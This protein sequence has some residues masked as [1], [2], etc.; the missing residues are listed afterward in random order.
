ML[1]PKT[2]PRKE[3]ASFLRK[4]FPLGDLGPKI[5]RS[6]CCGFLRDDCFHWDPLF[7]SNI[8]SCPGKSDDRECVWKKKGYVTREI[9]DINS[10]I[11]LVGHTYLCKTHGKSYS[12]FV[13]PFVGENLFFNETFLL[14]REKGWTIALCQMLANL[15]PYGTSFGRVFSILQAERD[16]KFRQYVAAST[17]KS[18]FGEGKKPQESHSLSHYYP[19]PVEKQILPFSSFP[20][21]KPTSRQFLIDCWLA[22]FKTFEKKIEERMQRL[23]A[24]SLSVD[25]TFKVAYNIA[26]KDNNKMVKQYGAMFIVLNQHGQV[27]TWALAKTAGLSEMEPVLRAFLQRPGQ[28]S[29]SSPVFISDRCC[30]DAK[31]LQSLGIVKILL[32]LFHAI[33]RICCCIAKKTSADKGPMLQEMKE[34]FRRPD[35][36]GDTRKKPT[37]DRL[38]MRDN[39]VKWFARWRKVCVL[40]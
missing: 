5:L 10:N 23:T 39:L 14:S 24:A 15:I 33:R 28:R 25:H 32:D 9:V 12:G 27:L 3:E 21:L 34:I 38:Q 2:P 18:T 40:S 8:F 30:Q 37:P 35:D 26:V 29:L 4:Y 6:H 36:T 31:I 20:L 22:Y 1:L 17:F 13:P 11:L 16:L 19:T 7:G